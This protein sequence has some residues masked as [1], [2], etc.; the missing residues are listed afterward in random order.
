MLSKSEICNFDN[1]F[2]VEDIGWLE[3][4]MYDVVFVEFSE[5]GDDLEEDVDDFFFCETFDFQEISQISI[6]A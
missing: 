5:T 2:V 4:A 3:I 6:E 1:S